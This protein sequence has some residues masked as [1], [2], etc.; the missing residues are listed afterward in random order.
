MLLPHLWKVISTDCHFV[1]HIPLLNRHKYSKDNVS[2]V[3]YPLIVSSSFEVEPRVE[4]WE[5]VGQYSSSQEETWESFNTL[6]FLHQMEIVSLTLQKIHFCWIR[7]NIHYFKQHVHFERT[8]GLVKLF[9]TWKI[10]LVNLGMGNGDCAVCTLQCTLG[11]YCLLP[12][13]WFWFSQ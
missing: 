10:L 1:L 8:Y 13:N 9:L 7:N 2:E 3:K 12:K 4:S 5:R 11:S 6:S